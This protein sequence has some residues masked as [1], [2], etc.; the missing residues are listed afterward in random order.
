MHRPDPQPLTSAP[1]KI[2]RRAMLAAPFMFGVSSVLSQPISAYPT[3]PVRIIVPYPPG[4]INDVLARATADKLQ[5][6]LGQPVL[7]ENRAGGGA[8]I[9]TQAVATAAPDGYTLLQVSAVHANNATLV[10]KLPYE[11]L[12]S[13]SFISLAFRAPVLLLVGAHVPV[14]TVGE[15]LALSRSKPGTLTY[16]ST[17]NGGAAHLMG[18]MLK[19]MA[20]IDVLHVPYKGAAPAMTDLMGGRI[21]FTFATYTAASAALKSGRARAIASTGAQ[22]LSVV[23]DIPTVSESGVPGFEAAGWWGYAAPAGTP[24]AVIARLHREISTA[25]ASPALRS[26]MLYEGVEVLGTTPDQFASYVRAE[27]NTWGKV[28]RNGNTAGVTGG[29]EREHACDQQT[30]WLRPLG[31]ATRGS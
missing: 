1:L 4:A 11:S 29:N 7:V 10:P 5:V 12:G 3:K 14:R 23:P 24:P 18:E 8:V 20:G 26:S 19:Q 17:G 2:S 21:D 22:R 28:I 13:F 16:G 15:L 31:A 30:A 6:G 27:I 25:L 9:G